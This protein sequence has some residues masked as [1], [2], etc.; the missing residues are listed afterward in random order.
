M[1]GPG[2]VAVAAFPVQD[3]DDPVIEIA[4]ELE[5]AITIG[6][7]ALKVSLAFCL[8]YIFPGLL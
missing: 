1:A 3:A 7:H 8:T 2:L 4:Q 6:Y 5:F